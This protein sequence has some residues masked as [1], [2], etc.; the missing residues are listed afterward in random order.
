MAENMSWKIDSDIQKCKTYF[1]GKHNNRVPLL[2][3]YI[4]SMFHNN[5]K[6]TLFLPLKYVLGYFLEQLS[7]GIHVDISYEYPLQSS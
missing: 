2:R 3:P 4:G 7:L 5:I 1:N 6:V